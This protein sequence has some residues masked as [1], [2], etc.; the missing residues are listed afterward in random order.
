MKAARSAGAQSRRCAEAA[1][2][3]RSR[4]AAGD[5]PVGNHGDGTDH[6]HVDQPSRRIQQAGRQHDVAFDSAGV[7]RQEGQVP[8]GHRSP[9]SLDQC[10]HFR[11]VVAEGRL[12]AA[13]RSRWLPS[14]LTQSWPWTRQ[15]MP[16]SAA[17]LAP[18][19]CQRVLAAGLRLQAPCRCSHRRP[20]RDQLL[21][22]WDGSEL[23]KTVARASRGEVSKKRASTAPH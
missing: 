9:Q 23:L 7:Y 5:K 21:Q 4:S 20:R 11:P 22:F 6:L 15:A 13:G 14:R 16:E 3:S 19:V 1:V 2:P 17:A 18:T 8:V 12:R 10:G